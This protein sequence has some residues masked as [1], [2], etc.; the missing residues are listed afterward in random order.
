M[1]DAPHQSREVNIT[2]LIDDGPLT[3]FQIGVI[4]CCAL[5]NLFDGADTQSIGV[6]APFI[7]DELGIE[8]ANFKWIFRR[9]W[10]GQPSGPPHSGRWPI[11]SVARSC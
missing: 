2:R 11:A 9:R 4:I 8:I 6:A 3:R 1:T 10:S 5:V 7:A